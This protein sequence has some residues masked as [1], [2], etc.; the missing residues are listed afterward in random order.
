MVTAAGTLFAICVI[1]TPIFVRVVGF[2]AI[3]MNHRFATIVKGIGMTQLEIRQVFERDDEGVPTRFDKVGTATTYTDATTVRRA[4][5]M[6]LA[7]YHS[8]PIPLE[9]WELIDYPYGNDGSETI[10]VYVNTLTTEIVF[11]MSE[12]DPHDDTQPEEP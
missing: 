3:T 1:M 9:M 8:M 5:G 6:R 2:H 10:W 11:T 7:A 4:Q 12:D